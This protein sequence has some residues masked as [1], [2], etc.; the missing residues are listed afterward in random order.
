MKGTHHYG[1]LG[2]IGILGSTLGARVSTINLWIESK[3]H[4]HG[5]DCVHVWVNA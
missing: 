4:E 1:G 5:L 3:G 2:G